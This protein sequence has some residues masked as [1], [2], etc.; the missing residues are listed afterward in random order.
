[1]HIKSNAEKFPTAKVIGILGH[2]SHP[3]SKDIKFD[4]YLTSSNNPLGQYFD[5]I[6]F[7]GHE[8]QDVLLIHRK[9]KSLIMGD[10]AISA[11]STFANR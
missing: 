2:K 8:V 6:S 1:M 11:H 9:T 7:E 3:A 10:L 5:F 4:D